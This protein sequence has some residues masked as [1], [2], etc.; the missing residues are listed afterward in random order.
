MGMLKLNTQSQIGLKQ[1]KYIIYIIT[2]IGI[3]DLGTYIIYV[4][5]SI[6]LYTVESVIYS[7]CIK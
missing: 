1:R 3:S 4:I 2:L 6:C 5:V 7:R